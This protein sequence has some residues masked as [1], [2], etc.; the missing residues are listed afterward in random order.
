MIDRPL[1]SL[2][3][4]TN[5]VVH[6]VFPVL[7][8]IFSQGLDNSLFE[9]VVSDNGNNP[10][11]KKIMLVY[12]NEHSN[13]LYRE[14]K[15][16]GF[17]SAPETYKIAN[18]VFIKF[19]NHRTK[20]V[21]GALQY[22]VSFVKTYKDTKVKPIVY[23]SNGVLH[24][25]STISFF[26]TFDQ[27]VGK[28]SYWSSWSTGMGI[29]KEDFDVLPKNIQYNSLFPHT[30]LLF[31]QRKR[32]HYI[33]DETV[34]LDEL[35][36][37]KTPKGKYDVFYAFEVEYLSILCDLLRTGDITLDTFKNLKEK[38]L[39]FVADLAIDFLIFHK[40]C[41]YDLSGFKKSSAVYYSLYEVQKKYFSD[42]LGA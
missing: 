9:V 2:C 5:G 40:Y 8:S 13:I 28:L 12:A 39:G 21:P 34:L 37:G 22:F 1:V 15:A 35:P 30:T 38:N 14:T 29:W 36:Q 10:E 3:I 7:D 41:S 18:G 31:S 17:L 4:P 32:G 20:L 26:L 6:W 24:S 23:F 27:F 19:I 42:F 25:K 16:D 33:I 11:F